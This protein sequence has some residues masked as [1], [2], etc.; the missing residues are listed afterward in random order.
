M[1]HLQCWPVLPESRW[2]ISSTTRQIVSSM[3]SRHFS[4]SGPSLSYRKGQMANGN[5]GKQ[6]SWHEEISWETSLKSWSA[7]DDCNT[8]GTECIW[9]I[10]CIDISSMGTLDCFM[11]LISMDMKSNHWHTFDSQDSASEAC[12]DCAS[13]LRSALVKTKS[14]KNWSSKWISSWITMNQQERWSRKQTFHL[15]KST[16]NRVK[17]K[18]HPNKKGTS[19]EKMHLYCWVPAL[20]FPGFPGRFVCCLPWRIKPKKVLKNTCDVPD[21]QQQHPPDFQYQ[22]VS[23]TR[24]KWVIHL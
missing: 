20:G 6:K 22:Y 24:Q 11:G 16:W 21:F 13:A 14:L 4:I 15:W 19:S 23:Y 2:L 3:M 12:L 5:W 7:G 10:D 1:K 9:C 17:P 18:H 8:W